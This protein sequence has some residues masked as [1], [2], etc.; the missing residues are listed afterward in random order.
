MERRAF[1]ATGL[2]IPAIGCGTWSVFDLPR[3]RED[4]AHRVVDLALDRGARLF[5]SS[6]MYGRAE[7][8]LSRALGERRGGAIVATKI[9]TELRDEGRSQFARQLD[10]YHGRVDILQVHNLAGWDRH[11]DWMQH[12]REAGRIGLIGATHYRASAFGELAQVM[13][14]GRIQMVQ[15]PVN[16]LERECEREILPLAEDLGLGVIA[17]RPFAGRALF[18]GPDPSE[19]APLGVRTWS[20]ALLKWTL[21]D[22]RV[23]VAIPATS[24]PGHASDNFEAAD[25][26]WFEQEQRQLVERLAAG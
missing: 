18:P 4:V 14:T 10:L 9:W 19:L 11:L 8:V 1:G 17:M 25:P 5:D 3:R 6:P 12:E 7:G 23:H 15:V 13:R 16:P 2:E 22:R 26:P 24:H 21:S 20:Q